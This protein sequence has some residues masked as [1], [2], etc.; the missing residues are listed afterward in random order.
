MLRNTVKK[1][2]AILLLSAI[3][4]AM[5]GCEYKKGRLGNVLVI[6]DS[7]STYEGHIPDGYLSW[8]PAGANET[9][10]DDVS[11]TWWHRLITET[12]SELIRNSSWS[13]STISNTGYN[14]ADYTDFSFVTRTRALVDSGFFSKNR[15]DTVII[16]GGLN[17]AWVPAPLGEVMLDE[18]ISG[19]DLYSTLPAMC[20]IFRLIYSA[21]PKSDVIV[22]VDSQLPDGMKAGF[23]EIADHYGALLVRLRPVEL[24]VGHPTKDGM[25]DIKTQ[26]ITALEE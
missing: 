22:V 23:L 16:Y 20:E 14:G 17:D 24:D 5:A 2:L 4:F 6:G 11:Y 8:Y 10:V 25:E 13:G 7:Y 18:E 12:G 15:I 3:L 1:V 19:E 26:I 21:S 9:A